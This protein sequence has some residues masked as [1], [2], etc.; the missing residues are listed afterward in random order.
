MIITDDLNFHL[1]D[2]NNRHSKILIEQLRSFGFDQYATGP[3]HREGHTLD[4]VIARSDLTP[5]TIDVGLPDEFS[6]HS[7]ILI[8]LPFQR[9]SLQFVDVTTRSWKSF[10]EELFRR[11]L[12][13]SRLCTGTDDLRQLDVDSLQELYDSTMSRLIEK[14]VPFRTVRRRHQPSTPWFDADCAAAKR[15]TRALERRYR[16]TGSLED[17]SA[18]VAQQRS[19]QR[20]YSQKQNKYWENR[21]T[22]SRG[23]PKKLW[24]N[25]A[26]VLRKEKVKPTRSEHISAENFSKAFRTKIED[27]RSSTADRSVST[28]HRHLLPIES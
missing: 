10:D 18:W 24:K 13:D 17:R 12:L 14:H 5:P 27:V 25:L 21:I 11:D 6:D 9:P 15:K 1:D 28:V 23:N 7:L 4:V 22:D 3:T 20:L 16:N 26:S 2:V 8:Q 19:K